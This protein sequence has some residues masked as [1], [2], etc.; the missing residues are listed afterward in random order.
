MTGVLYP[1][2]SRAIAYGYN[3]GA[4]DNLSRLS[5]L[6]TS[7]GSLSSGTLS[8]FSYLGLGQIVTENYPQPGVTLDYSGGTAATYAGLDNFGRVG[9]QP[10]QI[11]GGTA[12]LDQFNYMYDLAGNRL[13]RQNVAGT[14]KDE[15]YTYDGVYRVYASSRG[16]LTSSGTIAGTPVRQETWGLD[17]TGN[18][19]TYTQSNSG[20]LALSQTRSHNTAN[21]LQMIVNGG[22]TGLTYDQAGNTLTLPEPADSSLTL[23]CTYDAWNRLAATNDGTT[24]VTFSYD[25]LGRRISKS[26]AAT[27]THYYLAGQQVAETRNG[28]PA[29]SPE[30][31]APSYQYVWS[32]RYID[33]PVLCDD[34]TA[35][36][37]Y[38]RLYYLG[39]ANFNVTSV[40]ST[41]GAVVE[42]YVFDAYGAPTFYNSTWT[43]SSTTSSVNNSVL[44]TGRELDPETGLNFYRARYYSAGLGRFISRDPNGLGG[45]VD[46]FEYAGDNPANALDPTG[47]A[48]V[49]GW[50]K[51]P[52]PTWWPS[53]L[54][55]PYDKPPEID[56]AD[57]VAPIG[58]A[59]AR[60]EAIKR[61]EGLAPQVEEHL[62]KIAKEPACQ[63]V[64]HWAGE[65]RSFIKQMRAAAE[66]AGKKTAA[67]WESRLTEWESRLNKLTGE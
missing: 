49:V 28:S 27:A 55:W 48:I 21:Q 18:W 20:T 3:L 14:L 19:G 58:M 53:W 35:S 56:P 50:R 8:Q 52:P 17:A 33:A 7:G 31:L 4:D 32:P 38:P 42:R 10:W 46:L 37:T 54:Y 6:A 57:F 40:V 45:G 34:F 9:Q 12:A 23:S 30:S 64:S 60:K 61:L 62:S 36:P 24:A 25:G 16:S 29:S 39:D 1:S 51:T 65:V 13:T 59:F 5:Y 26:T 66:R 2:G 22:T 15:Q 41:S 11:A 43:S 44:Y 47:T 63:A 67:E